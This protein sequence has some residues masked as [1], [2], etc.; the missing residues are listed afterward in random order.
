MVINFQYTVHCR[1]NAIPYHCVIYHMNDTVE[2][3]YTSTLIIKIHSLLTT[4]I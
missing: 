2:K 4:E 3:K 1:I